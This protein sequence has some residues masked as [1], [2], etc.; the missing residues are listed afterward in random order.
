[1]L[2]SVDRNFT[3]GGPAPREGSHTAAQQTQGSDL[4]SL[5]GSNR[6]NGGPGISGQNTIFTR[7]SHFPEID[8]KIPY[9]EVPVGINL[10]H[11]AREEEAQEE[12]G[13]EKSRH[14]Y[15]H[16]PSLQQR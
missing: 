11:H 8:S 13:E 5:T 1:M 16:H 2:G 14:G 10:S 9:Q 6:E 4:S 12:E 15:E 7:F 3:D